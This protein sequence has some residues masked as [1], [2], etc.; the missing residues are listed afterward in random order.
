MQDHLRGGKVEFL[1]YLIAF[2]HTGDKEAL[3]QDVTATPRRR[4][5]PE[6]LLRLAGKVSPF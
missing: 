4:F 2:I 6:I 1:E 5:V 3:V